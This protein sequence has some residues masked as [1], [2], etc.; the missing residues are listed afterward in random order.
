MTIELLDG[1][2]VDSGDLSINRT[3]YRVT[4]DDTAEDVTALVKQSDKVKVFWNFDRQRDNERASDDAA[5]ARGEAPVRVGS[6][7][8]FGNFVEQ[9]VTDPLA[10]PLEAADRT[11]ARTTKS[12]FG[13]WS[14]RLIVIAVVVTAFIYFGGPALLKKM[15]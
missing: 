3:T 4:N 10:A 2:M 12:I 5:A 11:I 15:R 6:T 14:G 8:I 7:S 13:T 9:I 1:R